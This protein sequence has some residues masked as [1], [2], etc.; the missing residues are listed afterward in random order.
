[1][2]EPASGMNPQ[3]VR[4]LIDLIRG[5]NQQGLSILLIEHNMT[6]AMELSDRL[7]VLDHGEK[8]AEGTPDEVQQNKRVIDAY[9]GREQEVAS[10]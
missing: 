3:E 1:M 10:G 8:I 5:I 2:D 6:V 4:E 7:I 9:L